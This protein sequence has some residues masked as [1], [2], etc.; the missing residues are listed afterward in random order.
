MTTIQ[1]HRYDIWASNLLFLAFGLSVLMGYLRQRDY[2]APDLNTQDYIMHY[3]IAPVL[4]VVYYYIRKGI[5][6]VKTLF[7]ALYGAT[8]LNILTSSYSFISSEDPLKTFDFLSQQ[9]LYL[10]ASVLLLL[11]LWSFQRSSTTHEA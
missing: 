4:L 7:L 2:F 6:E 5:R 1:K 3:L 11:S 9:L 10:A 8:L